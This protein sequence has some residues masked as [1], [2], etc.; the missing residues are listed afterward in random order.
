MEQDKAKQKVICI[1]GNECIKEGEIAVVERVASDGSL[2]I[3]G[4]FM[5]PKNFKN[6]E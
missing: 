5:N 1:N 3:R 2:L 6:Y 4:F